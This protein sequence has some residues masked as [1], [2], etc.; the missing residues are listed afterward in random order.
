[1]S[2][3]FIA[4]RRIAGDGNIRYGVGSEP[5]EYIAGNR[6]TINLMW[7]TGAFI[8]VLS[9][10]N[11]VRDTESDDYERLV[12]SIDEDTEFID[13]NSVSGAGKGVL[14]KIKNMKINGH[15]I[16]NFYF[17]L[18]KDVKRIINN[19][20]YSASISLLGADF[21]DYCKYEHDVED[22]IV[23]RDF[24]YDKYEKHHNLYRYKNKDMIYSDLF[25]MKTE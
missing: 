8:S 16:E 7:D 20:E 11:F 21:I 6:I 9:V 14:R 2:E 25:T 12:K 22:D 18:V 4:H 17:L 13:Y 24:D 23:V 10:A 1:M 19:T 5:T 15:L 3:I